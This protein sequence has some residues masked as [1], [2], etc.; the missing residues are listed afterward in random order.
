MKNRI[1]SAAL[2]LALVSMGMYVFAQP[3][4]DKHGSCKYC[5]MDRKTFA[6]SRMVVVYEDGS[7]FGACSLHCVAIDLAL[8]I[9]QTPKTIQVADFN[10]QGL[11][12]AEK[13]VWVIGGQKPGVMSRRAKWAFEKKED[14][15]AF[16]K[17]HGGAPADFETAL[18]AAYEDMYTDTKMI[19]E[20]RKAKRMKPGS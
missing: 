19:R 3:D 11:I 16:I 6:H 7:E 4:V 17:L 18:K 13:A 15:D 20:R 14:A 5:G 12:D 9:D 2:A 1:A 8:N 10:T